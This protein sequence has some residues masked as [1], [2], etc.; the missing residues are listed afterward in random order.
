MDILKGLH[1]EFGW[2]IWGLVGVGVIWFL[3]GGALSPVAHEGP[4]IKPPA[5]LDS[6]EA[7]G[8]AYVS[9]ANPIKES[10]NLPQSATGVIKNAEEGIRDFITQS[11]EA[12]K[13]HSSSL[14]SKSVYLDGVAGAQASGPQEEYVRLVASDQ[15]VSSISLS[16]AY[17]RGSAY[18][19]SVALPTAANLPLL[20]TPYL[21]TAV[22]LPADG[23]VLVTSGRSPI[24]TSFR[25]NMCTGYLDQF[26]TFTPDLRKDCPEPIKE[27]EVSGPYEEA[28][29]REF[30]QA[31]PRCRAFEGTFPDNVSAICKSFVT[32][33]LNY[34]SCAQR[35]ESAQGFFRNEWRLFLEKT[36]EL[37]KNK[38]E[39]IRLYDS[40][41]NALDAI[42]F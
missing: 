8:G 26:Q 23:R 21:K 38:Q 13:I 4:Y 42:T 35:H 34:N 29:C 14:L 18:G 39:I 12:K 20:G 16:G 32:Q 36:T 5:P 15:A 31:L 3:T 37:W 9:P 28:S 11:Q 27:L 22:S 19:V 40:K 7:Y 17:L 33:N 6:G 10:L 24:G 41:G 2:L 25:V 30:V 1:E